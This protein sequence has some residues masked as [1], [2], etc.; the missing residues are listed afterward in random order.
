MKG[1]IQECTEFWGKLWILLLTPYHQVH[2]SMK[3]IYQKKS[4]ENVLQSAMPIPPL[5]TSSESHPRNGCIAFH[6]NLYTCKPARIEQY[7]TIP[8]S[9]PAFFISFSTFSQYFLHIETYPQQLTVFTMSLEMAPPM[10]CNFLMATCHSWRKKTRK[11]SVSAAAS[12]L[13]K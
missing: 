3:I 1:S 9:K 6:Q 10:T 13:G 11:E 12:L 2:H 5:G 8:L 4:L 7:I